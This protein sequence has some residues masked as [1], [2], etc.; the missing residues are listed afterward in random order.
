V[1]LGAPLGAFAM[2]Y[3]FAVRLARSAGVIGAIDWPNMRSLHR[4]PTPRTGG[5]AVLGG[6]MLVWLIRYGPN[7]AEMRNS[8]DLLVVLGALL[9]N[10]FGLVPGR[11]SQRPP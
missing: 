6:V 8:G 1:D 10:R 11:P 4:R 7:R 3:W 9:V 2:S 5:L